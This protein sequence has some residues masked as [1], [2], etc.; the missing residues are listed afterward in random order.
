MFYNPAVK[1]TDF[2]QGCPKDSKIE[3]R[4]KFSQRQMLLELSSAVEGQMAPRSGHACF[5]VLLVPAR[6]VAR[7]HQYWNGVSASGSVEFCS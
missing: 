4:K 7:T 3:T 2:Q 5:E 1:M 6:S